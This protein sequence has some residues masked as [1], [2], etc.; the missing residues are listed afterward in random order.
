MFHSPCIR[1]NNVAIAWAGGGLWELELCLML[2]FD[3]AA[4]FEPCPC[5]SYLGGKSAS[6]P[7]LTAFGNPDSEIAKAE[8]CPQRSVL[9][10]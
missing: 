7:S 10:Q 2:F 5:I 8:L 6:S 9:Y 1:S 4:K 3:V